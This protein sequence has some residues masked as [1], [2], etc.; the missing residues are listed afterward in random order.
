[1]HLVSEVTVMM[2][3]NNHQKVVIYGCDTDIYWRITNADYEKPA[4]R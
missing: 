1:M 3:N 2:P 4:I